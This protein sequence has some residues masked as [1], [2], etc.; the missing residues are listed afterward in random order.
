MAM[1]M[2]MALAMAMAMM[3]M[4]AASLHHELCFSCFR[5]PTVSQ[6]LQAL[7]KTIKHSRIFA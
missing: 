4:I 1:A 2:A 7:P 6:D 3:I 5:F